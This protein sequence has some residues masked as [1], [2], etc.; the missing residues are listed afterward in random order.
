MSLKL[1]F[2]IFYN[3][4]IDLQLMVFILTYIMLLSHPY[5]LLT[6]KGNEIIAFDIE[7][8]FDYT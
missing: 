3:Y 7:F 5:I 1:N 8:L 6:S 4:V 2:F